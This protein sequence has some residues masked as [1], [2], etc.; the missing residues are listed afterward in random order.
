M[1]SCERAS[2]ERCMDESATWAC[3]A[4][5]ALSNDEVYAIL[6]LRS[7]V[8]VVE[9]AC[10]Y[11]D[12]DGLDQVGWHYLY[13]KGN[14]LLAYQRCLPPGSAYADASSLGRVVVAPAQRGRALARQLVQRGIDFNL[15]TWP[16]APLLIGAQS[17]LQP[18]YE[19]LSFVACSQPYLEDGIPHLTMR[20]QAPTLE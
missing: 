10:I 18:F 8:F 2:K 9:Q 4:F 17:Y 19:S 5:N 16:G 1:P 20:Y 3:K 6:A 12:P 11:L 13:R 14:A 15:A 7:A